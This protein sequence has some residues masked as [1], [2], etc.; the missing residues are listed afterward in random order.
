MSIIH[1]RQSSCAGFERNQKKYPLTYEE[2]LDSIMWITVISLSERIQMIKY[3]NAMFFSG[4]PQKENELLCPFSLYGKGSVRTIS[5]ARR[6]DLNKNFYGEKIAPI[7]CFDFCRDAVF[8]TGNAEARDSFPDNLWL[9]KKIV[10]YP[11]AVKKET[12]GVQRLFENRR[13][14][15]DDQRNDSSPSPNPN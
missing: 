3:I 10:N 12:E 11:G 7:N 2:Y 5:G 4:S 1:C 8:A 9:V 13:G 14:V 6:K 15:A